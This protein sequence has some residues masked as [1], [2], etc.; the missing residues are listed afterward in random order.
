MD[1]P[2]GLNW[3]NR[4]RLDMEGNVTVSGHVKSVDLHLTETWQKH[5]SNPRSQPTII[6]NVPDLDGLVIQNLCKC[7]CGS[8]CECCFLKPPDIPSQM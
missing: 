8:S 7:R 2:G 6:R 5:D 4:V 1:P 3:V